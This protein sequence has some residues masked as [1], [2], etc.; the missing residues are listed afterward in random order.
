MKKAPNPAPTKKARPARLLDLVENMDGQLFT[1][2]CTIPYNQYTYDYK[3]KICFEHRRR[4]EPDFEW[5][6]E[7]WVSQ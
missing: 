6:I 7:V 4:S 2:V 5:P 3:L 1:D